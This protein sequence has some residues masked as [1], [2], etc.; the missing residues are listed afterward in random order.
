[1][2]IVKLKNGKQKFINDENDLRDLIFDELGSDAES[3][4]IKIIEKMEN[5]TKSVEFLESENKACEEEKDQLEYDNN[6]LENEIDD[7]KE[8]LNYVKETINFLKEEY[9]YNEDE[10]RK[11]LKAIKSLENNIEI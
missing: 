11:L 3:E 1:M 5:L 2:S 7:L 6:E 4:Y 8:S 10:N 9:K